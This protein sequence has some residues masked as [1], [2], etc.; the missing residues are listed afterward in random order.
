MTNIGYAK[1]G[2]SLTLDPADEGFQGDREAPQLLARLARRSPHVKW[3]IVGR[4]RG[5]FDPSLTNVV[6]LWDG[7]IRERCKAFP[8][9][10]GLYHTWDAKW[11]GPPFPAVSEI[12]GFEDAIVSTIREMDGMVIHC[13]QH[14]TSQIRIPNSKTTWAEALADPDEHVTN[15]HD[16]SKAYGRFLIRGLNALGDRTNGQAPVVWICTDPRNYVKARDVKWPTGLDDILAQY[17][18]VRRQRHDRFRDPRPPSDF[19][20]NHDSV[21]LDRDGEIWVVKHTYRLADLELMILPDNWETWGQATWAERKPVGVASTSYDTRNL[22]P[23]RSEFIRDVVLGT[24]PD[25]EVWG[26]WDK[27][28][29][30]DVAEG[31]VKLNKPSEFSAL[32]NSWRVTVS[33]PGIGSSW[34]VAKPY[35]CFAANVVCFMMNRV[36]DL[37]WIIP[38]RRKVADNKFVG[39]VDGVKLYS[40]R[41][42]WTEPDLKLA[43][44]LR[45]ETADEFASL[46]RVVIENEA[47]WQA[48]ARA[49][50]ELLSRRWAESYLE[51]EIER[52]LGIGGAHV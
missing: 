15:P 24:Y 41:D 40:V 18:W 19:G 23:R 13:G 31:T 3:V 4:N 30:A 42:D 7:D 22:E 36:D 8:R 25:A 50:R 14:G 27:K 11:A 29:L 49:Q 44:W 12:T 43:R 35:Q 48:L 21:K 20:L 32:L 46:S 51:S 1:L 2:R 37:G 47:A 26:K 28:S 45:V 6:N 38:S 39:E 34:T 16:W 33:L 9:V 17:N 52:K 10:N 5:T